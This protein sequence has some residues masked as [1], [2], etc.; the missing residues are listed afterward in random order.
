MTHD[1]KVQLS[2]TYQQLSN[3]HAELCDNGRKGGRNESIIRSQSRIHW[4]QP[5]LAHGSRLIRASASRSGHRCTKYSFNLSITFHANVT[6]V[7]V[8]SKRQSDRGGRKGFFL[9]LHHAHCTSC[10]FEGSWR[11]LANYR[12]ARAPSVS[13]GHSVAA[14]KLHADS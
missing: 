3:E 6:R 4:P 10:F 8:E 5:Q 9:G 1:T 7:T 13:F 11:H 2:T 12:P 14:V